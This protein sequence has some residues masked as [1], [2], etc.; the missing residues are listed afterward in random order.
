MNRKAIFW[1]VGIVLV[2]GL[3]AGG[4]YYFTTQ[5]AQEEAAAETEAE[6]QTAVARLG[7]PELRLLPPGSLLVNVARGPVVDQAALYRALLDGHLHAAGLDVWY[8]Y[9]ASPAE[10]SHTP[11][12]DFPFHELDNVVMSPHRAGLAVETEA[13]RMQALAELLN[14]ACRGD[15]VPNRVDVQAGY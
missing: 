15:S 10:R 5:A 2:L 9:P 1:I 14:A 8:R 7:E 12:A 6:M 3:A 13:L 4:Y 11:P